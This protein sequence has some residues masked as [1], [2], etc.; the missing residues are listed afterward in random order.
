MYSKNDN[1]ILGDWKLDG[2][3]DETADENFYENEF[4]N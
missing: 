1:V 3:P 2:Q 4:Y